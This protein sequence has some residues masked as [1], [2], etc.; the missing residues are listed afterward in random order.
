[1]KHLASLLLMALVLGITSVYGQSS[2]LR[3]FTIDIY[4]DS[5]FLRLDTSNH[6]LIVYKRHGK[7]MKK[8]KVLSEQIFC[9]DKKSSID[10]IFLEIVGI[11]NIP[12]NIKRLQN[13]HAEFKVFVNK[14]AV[15]NSNVDLVIK[16]G[17]VMYLSQGCSECHKILITQLAVVRRPNGE[18]VT[19]NKLID[20]HVLN[21]Y[22]AKNKIKRF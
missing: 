9:I 15:L 6:V 10:V 8:L 19:G 12:I 3:Y 1:M 17:D 21:Q 22:T 16:A 18:L 4:V 7:K 14:N 5:A 13:E 2:R 11:V 20:K